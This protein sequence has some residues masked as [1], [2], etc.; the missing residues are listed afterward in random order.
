MALPMTTLAAPQAIRPYRRPWPTLLSWLTVTVVGA[1][2][3]GLLVVEVV[4]PPP[5]VGTVPYYHAASNIAQMVTAVP[6]TSFDAVAHDP[7]PSLAMVT[8][9]DEAPLTV[10]QANGHRVPEVLVVMT[11]NC[12]ACAPERWAVLAALGR[13]GTFTN[14]GYATSSQT[15]APPSLPTFSLREVHFHSPYLAFRAVELQGSFREGNGTYPTI[16]RLTSR[17][18]RLLQRVDAEGTSP[19]VATPPGIP[20]TSVLPFVDLGGRAV[21]VGSQVAPSML[22][23]QRRM[24]VASGLSD[25]TEPTTVA[26]LSAAN[27]LVD[28]LCTLT[29]GQPQSTCRRGG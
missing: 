15:V 16:G 27:E 4:V 17:E 21:V 3:C 26:I 1:M 20:R 9:V 12:T 7:I 24:A 14:L 25:P 19:I 22:F 10:R 13:F 11:E 18:R 2:I 23:G 6:A 29:H 8:P 28:E 5:K